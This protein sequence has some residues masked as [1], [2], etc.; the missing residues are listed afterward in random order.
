MDGTTVSALTQ[1]LINILIG[2]FSLVTLS[3]AA[4]GIQTLFNDHKDAKRKEES[5]ARDREYHEA[6]M[7]EYR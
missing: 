2:S 5:D 3:W 4:V 6:R 7:K 1:A